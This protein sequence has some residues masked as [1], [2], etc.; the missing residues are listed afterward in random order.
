MRTVDL[1]RDSPSVN[2][3]VRGVYGMARRGK[4]MEEFGIKS[5]TSGLDAVSRTWT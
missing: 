2:V 3:G 5:L 1:D 4:E